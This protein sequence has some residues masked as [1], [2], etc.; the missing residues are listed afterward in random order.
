MQTDNGLEA[1]L[2]LDAAAINEAAVPDAGFHQRIMVRVTASTAA[3]MPAPRRFRMPSQ[4]AFAVGLALVALGL[5][6]AFSRLSA[7][8]PA[9]RNTV[10]PALAGMNMVADPARG[11]VVIFGGGGN[12]PTQPSADT[13]TWD[14]SSWTRLQPRTSPP[15]RSEFSMAYD[16]ARGNV[17]IFGGMGR[18]NGAA[19]PPNLNDTWIW[20]GSNWKQAHSPVEPPATNGAA[21]V[22]DPSLRLTVLL[23]GGFTWI[24]NGTAW[25]QG[26]PGPPGKGAGPME[27][28]PASGTI[29]LLTLNR[30]SAPPT[31]ATWHFD[32]KAWSQQAG[33][34]IAASWSPIRLAEDPLSGSL[35]GVD[36]L[37]RTWSWDSSKW[38]V[39]NVKKVT[40]G[41]G[42][43]LTYDPIRH[44]V[45]IFG[46]QRQDSRAV[47]DL[48]VWDGNTWTSLPGGQVLPTYA[49][50]PQ[51]T[52]PA[53]SL[54]A[55]S[56]QADWLIRRPSRLK[57]PANGLFE[58]TDGGRTWQLRLEFG[59]IYDGTSW[60]PSGLEGVVWTIDMGSPSCSDGR[61]CT[62]PTETLTVYATTDGGRHWNAHA[63]TTWPA[64][65]VSF[66]GV[67]GWAISR[68]EPPTLYHTGD[69][70]ATWTAAGPAPS[71]GL[72]SHTFG[73][74]DNPL[75]FAS[76]Q[77]G[78]YAT[79]QAGT[80]GNS[81]LLMTTDGG[82]TWAAQPVQ[83]P[84]GFTESQM[85]LGFPQILGDGNLLLPAFIGRETDPNNF[86]VSRWYVYSSADGG[87]T[88]TSPQLLQGPNG[89]RPTGQEFEDSF[90]DAQH[91][92]FTAI[93][94]RS[95]GEPVPQAAPAVGRTTDGG[96][97]WQIFKSPTIIQLEFSDPQRGWALAVSG[98]DNTNVLLR[99]TD[100]GAHWQTAKIP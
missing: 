33:A 90:L 34:D 21:M 85:M 91:W 13:W 27:Y 29:V 20:D 42:A 17:V 31:I 25:S 71:G 66:R 89:V 28:D 48:S 54:T 79:G 36:G 76:S 18:A 23:D 50:A 30:A 16:A 75:Q 94:Q 40:A 38:T 99:T 32:G 53:L 47:S 58:S 2:R 57:G 19:P 55:S 56:A 24:W 65:S 37:G 98:P 7:N 41:A 43:A 15:A 26:L 95:A 46:G 67:E 52:A 72:P 51:S 61:T 74:G 12:D 62:G 97:T 83:P 49:P 88:W 22:Y 44:L 93:D 77:R 4:L 80:P 59:G 63:A 81:G 68:G 92:W 64:T 9:Y 86:S 60:S 45:L 100:G 14:G 87:A 78:W 69:A 70:G 84:A 6:Y 8:R 11:N 1:R 82:R 3:A 39:L 73:V 96:R 35:M 5:G 10:A